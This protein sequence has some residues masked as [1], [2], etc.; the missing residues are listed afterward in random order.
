[1]LR[2]LILFMLLIAGVPSA[3]AAEDGYRLWLRYPLAEKNWRAAASPRLHAVVVEGRS[4]MRNAAAGELKRGIAGLIG[5]EP[6]RSKALVDGAILIGAARDPHIA[7]LRLPLAQLGPEGFLVRSIERSNKRLIVVAANSDRGLLYGAF[8]LLREL[9]QGRSLATLNLRERPDSPLRML[10]HWDNLD[11][12]VERGY[13]G[14]SLWHWSELPQ[15]IDPRLTYYARANASIG[16]N[17]AVLT[18]VNADATVLTTPYLRKVAAIAGVLRPWGMRTY[19]TARFSAPIDIGGLPTADPAD[20]RVRAWWKAKADEIYRIVPDF[21]GFLVKANSEGQPGPGDYG[22][23]HADGANMLADAVAR[24]G[25]T[26][27]WRAFVYR[28]AEGSDRARQA[29]DEF[30]PLDG[31]FRSNVIVQVKNGPVDFQPREPFHPLF[32]QMPGT[33]LAL[34]VQATKEYLG[35]ATHLAYLAPMWAE[36]FGSRTEHPDRGPT[37]ADHIQAMAAVANTGDDRNWTGS[38]FD[39]AN[40]YAAGRLAWDHDLSPAAIAGEWVRQTWSRDPEVVETI[41][42]MMMGSREAVVN[43]MTPLGLNHLMAS[44]HHYG[45]GPWVDD[46]PRADW[47]PVYFHR[48]DQKGIGFDR[49]AAGSNAVAQYRS[50]IARCLASRA[51]VPDQLLLWFHHVRWDEPMR[52]GRTLW[53]ELIA[54]YDLG[55]QAVVAMRRGWHSLAGRVDHQRHAVVEAK[56]ARQEK[57]A[58]WWRDASIAYWQAVARRPLPAGVTAPP[59]SLATYRAIRF[60][61][62]PGD[63]E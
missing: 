55:L 16:I 60:R 13:A 12:F 15:R 17:A 45:P 20:A 28:A 34:E 44:G 1:M 33:R 14:R 26:V 62:V 49:T 47:N 38:D 58:R 23:S 36:V 31:Q 40:W 51:C 9:Q 27:L 25:G 10:N 19:L 63:P 4:A 7:A 29:F 61:H 57:E 18:N 43:Y 6:I 2:Y 46:L 3:V 22:R 21:G 41:T 56:L 54:R 8:A 39:Q 37:V 32:G 24:H 35:F 53:E 48:A 59:H 30:K 52:S 11:G 5:R 42:T 50:D